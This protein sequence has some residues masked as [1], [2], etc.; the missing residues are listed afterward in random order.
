[1][2]M[3]AS[4]SILD[5]NILVIGGGKIRDRQKKVNCSENSSMCFSPCNSNDCVGSLL[6]S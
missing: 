5:D 3:A 2:V 1:M 4:A 6:K